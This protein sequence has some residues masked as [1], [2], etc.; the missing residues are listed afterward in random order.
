MNDKPKTV[1]DRTRSCLNCGKLFE[2]DRR[3]AN[4]KFCNENCRMDYYGI[5]PKNYDAVERICQYCHQPFECSRSTPT[6]IYCSIECATA[7]YK[8]KPQVEPEEEE[9]EETRICQYCG[10]E[11]VCK[12]ANSRQIHCSRECSANANSEKRKAYIFKEERKCAYC[13]NPFMWH[14]NKSGQKYCSRECRDAATKIK[15]RNRQKKPSDTDEAL[16]NEVYLKVLDIISKMNQSK[17]ASFGG[18]YI[19]YRVIGDISDKTRYEVLERDSYECQVCTRKDSL[20]LHHLIKRQYGGNHDAENL[21]T[22]CASCHRHIETGDLDHAVRKCF[23]N[24]KRYYGNDDRNKNTRKNEAV[25][26]HKLK[27]QLTVLFDKLRNSPV[28]DDA[29]IMICLDEALD[30]IDTD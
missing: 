7:F 2:Y 19:D 20:H 9:Y 27:D 6:K 5:T 21:I 8:S 26:I 30:L 4:R 24:A 25:D 13:G 10:K 16:R 18:R 14:S 28:G 11:F 1:V 29:E 12:S 15:I 23:K 17:G 22:L 3:R